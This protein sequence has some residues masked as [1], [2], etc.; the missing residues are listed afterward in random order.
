MGESPIQEL[1]QQVSHKYGWSCKLEKEAESGF[2]VCYVILSLFDERNFVSSCD[3]PDS[4]EEGRKE[5]QAAASQ[6]ALD[7]LQEEI[8]KQEAKPKKELTEVFPLYRNPKNDKLDSNE[9]PLFV[10]RGSSAKNWN[11]CVW[12]TDKPKVVGIDTEGNLNTPPILVQ[13]A[14]DSCVILEITSMNG[15]RL[16]K[17]LQ[18]LLADNEIVKVFCDNFSH[19]D[20]RSLGLLPPLEKKNKNDK[21]AKTPPI[22][23]PDFSQGPIV[24]LEA[25]S[26][27]LLGP[28]SVARG[29]SRI[30]NLA[31]T[32][33][34]VLVGKPSNRKGGSRLK[35]IGRF[36]M[37]EQGKA[38]PLT[39]LR[40]LTRKQ[41]LYA[42]TDAW[43]TLQAYKR[44]CEAP[45]TYTHLTLP[46]NREV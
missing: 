23:L 45:V 10:I 21:K 19:K 22:D 34:N 33:L 24:D 37:I 15:N 1:K 35:D 44:L 13:I 3:S 16:S 40:D 30:V 25:L 41:Q 36:A 20:K 32:D 28:V 29:L 7:G 14:T 2:W 17:N 39:A 6:A 5:G 46:T 26:A 38:P 42:A 11:E 8:A 43:V 27:K 12:T 4:T 18:R 31:M 9:K